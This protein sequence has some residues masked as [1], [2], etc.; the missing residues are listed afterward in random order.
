[1]LGQ[2]RIVVLC[3]LAVLPLLAAQGQKARIVC[4]FSNWAIYRP[5]VGRY[6]IDDIPAEM[7]T[8]IIYSF[9]G[10]DDTN[11]Y[12]VLV[13]DPEVDLE[14]SGFRNF[15]ELR[16][17]YPHAKY[18][19]AV[20]GWAEGGKKY[21]QMVAVKE[22]RQSFIASVVQFMKVYNFDGFDLD[23]EYPGAADRGGSF[24][25]KDKFFYFVE[26]LRR[27]FDREGRGW[28]I[29][30]A[31]PVAN[32]RLQEG[33][34]VP[35]LCENLDAIHC[36]TYDLRGNWA[37]FADVHSPLYKR[38]HDQWAYEKLNVNDGVQLWVNYGCPPNKLVV[39]VPFYGRTFTLSAST[40][41]PTLGSYINKEAGGG[42]PGPYTNATGFLAYYEICTEVQDEEKGWTKKWDDVGL[43][44]YTYKGTQFVGYEDEKSLRYKMDW[45]KQKGYAGAMTWAIDM[46]DF[47]GLCGPENAL[48]KVLY[49]GMKDY[50][51]PEP[52]V[53]TTPRPEWNRPPSTM[54]SDGD[55]TSSRPTTTT[56]YRP[57]PTSTTAPTTRTTRRTTVSS[58]TS[59]RKPT[60]ILPPEPT[61]SGEDREPEI[62][63]APEHEDESEI[64]CSGY[65]DFVPS[66]D[67]TKYYRCVHGQPVEFVCKPGTV[68]HTAL[69][70]CDWPENA[71]RPECRTKAKLIGQ[72]LVADEYG[73]TLR[74]TIVLL[75]VLLGQHQCLGRLICHYTT[76][77]QGRA[78]PYS[79]RI[80]DI[81]GELCTHVVYNFVGVDSEE[82]ELAMLQREIDVVQN[83]FGRFVDL[84]KR[85]PD[86]KMHVAVGGWDHGGAPFSRMAAYRNRR[87]KFIESVVKFMGSY[88]FDGIEL[89][90]LYPGSVER[91]GTNNDKDNF[92]YLVEE[93]KTAFLK[94]RQPWEVAIQVPADH[95]RFEVGYDQPLLCES[96]DFVHI[97][98]YDLRGSW[99]GFADVHSPMNDRPHDQ[100]IY[101]GLNVKAGVESWLR[102]GCSPSKVILGVPFLGRTYTLRNSQQ[103]SVGSLTSG[104]GQKGQH[105]YTEGYLGYFEI[106]QK[107]KERNWRTFWD[108]VG[109]CPYTY[110]GNQWI[111]YENEQSLK[112]KVEFVKAK[113]L[114]GIYAFSLDLDDYRGKCGEPYPLMST[115]ASLLKK[116]HSSEIGFAFERGDKLICY[117]TNWSHAR[118]NE[119]S[120]ELEDIPGQ[121]C[122][123]VA[124]AFVGVD[125]A[126]SKLVSRKPEYDEDRN[127]FERFRDL[128]VR[129]AHLRLIVSVGGWTHGGGPFSKMASER[130]TRLQ[131]VASAVAFMEQYQLDGMEIVW[132][133]PGAPERGGKRV[134]KDNFYYLVRELREGFERAGKGWEVSVQVPVDRARIAVGYQQEWL[135]QAADYIHLAGY[136]LRGPWTGYADV[137]SILKR[138]SHDTHYYYTFNIEDGIAAWQR[139]GCRADQLVLGLPL[140][141]R[142]YVLK[143]STIT[144]PGAEASGPGPV[145]PITNDPGLLGYFELCEMLKDRNWTA[146]WD[147][148][149]QAPYVYRADQWIGYESEQ[150]LMVKTQWV[151]AQGLGGIYAYTLDLDDYRGECDARPITVV[152]LLHLLVLTRF[153]PLCAGEESRLVCYFTNWSPDRDGEYAFNVNDIPVDLCTHVTYTFAGVDEHTFELR[154]TSGKYDILEQGYERFASLK[155]ANPDVKL[156]L[157]VGGWAHGAEPFQKMAATLNGREVFIA[158]VVEFLRRYDFDGIEIVWLWPGSP[159][160]GGTAS[161][162][163]NLYLLIAELKSAFREA[164]HDAWEVI[165]QVPLDRYRIELGYHQSQLC[166]VAD[167]VY[168]TGYDLRGSWNGFT[169]VHSPI[170]N[171]PFDTGALKDLN[172]KG[173]IQHWIK[174]GCPARKIVLGVPLFG[175]TYTLQNGDVHGLAAPTIGPG[176]AG[177]HTKD[178]GYRAYFE[179]C[180]DLKQSAW[181]IDW[182]ERG[183]CPYAYFGDQWVGYENHISIMEKA[184]FAK[185]QGL[186]GVYAFSLDLDDYRGK[187]GAPYP[188]LKALRN[189][190]KPKKLCAPDD[191]RDF[192]IFLVA[193]TRF[194][195]HYTTWSRD[196]PDEGSFQINDIPGNLCS[197]VV[198]NFLGV[199]ETSYQL[200]LLQPEY[201][202]GERALERFAALKDQYPHLKLLIAVG[203][204]A[205]G[206]ARFSE[207]AKF[208][209]RRNQFIG[210]VMKFLHQYR[211][212]GIELVWLYPGNF[213][214]G[215]A[216]EDKDTFL[217]LVS[218]LAKVI[219][220]EAK[221]WELVI[222]VPV[223]ISRMS[224]GYHQ[225]ELCA[226][227]DFVHMV[228]YD[229]RGWW[230]NFADVH[231]PLAPR[232]ND[233]VME[234]FEHVNVGDGVQDWLD[235]GCPPEKVTLG[236]ALFGRTYLLDDPLDNTIGAVTIG[237]GDPGPYSNE[238]GYL[239]YCEFCGNL[240]SSEWTKKWDD[241]GLCPYAY[242]ETTW[243]G[244]EDE[245]SLQEKINYVKRKGLGGLYAFSLDLDDYRGACGDPFPLTRFLSKYHDE[246]KIKDWHIFW[247]KAEHNEVSNHATTFSVGPVGPRAVYPKYSG[248]M[249]VCVRLQV[250]AET[251]SE[252]ECR[253]YIE[254]AIQDLKSESGS[255]QL[256]ALACREPERSNVH[257]LLVEAADENASIEN[258]IDVTSQEEEDNTAAEEVSTEETDTATDDATEEITP[259]EEVQEQ[260]FADSA[261]NDEAAEASENV[262]ASEETEQDAANVAD[263][264]EEEATASS[265]D[266]TEDQEDENVTE[267]VESIVSEEAEQSEEV[268][269]ETEELT[270]EESANQV[271][272]DAT[273]EEED[274]DETDNDGEQ[275]ED[276][277]TEDVATEEATESAEE[278][279]DSQEVEADAA[280]NEDEE[281][282][283]EDET[284]DGVDEDGDDVDETKEEETS[285][286]EEKEEQEEIEAQTSSEDDDDDDLEEENAV[287]GS[288][289]DREQEEIEI[290]SAEAN[291]A[292]SEEDSAREE[293]I[294]SSED[295]DQNENEELEGTGNSEEQETTTE[296]SEEAEDREA[297][298][299]DSEFASGEETEQ[300]EEADSQE[301]ADD[302]AADDENLSEETESETAESITAASEEE[303]SEAEPEAT[304]QSEEQVVDSQEAGEATEEASQDEPSAEEQVEE[305]AE[306]A[307]VTEEATSQEEQEAASAEEPTDSQQA[308]EDSAEET[309]TESAEEETVAAVAEGES[310]EESVVKQDS[311]ESLAEAGAEESVEQSAEASE[312]ASQDEESFPEED[313]LL[314]YEIPSN[315][316]DTSHVYELLNIND[317]ASARE[318]ALQETA[319]VI[320]RDLKRIYDNSIKPLETLYKY[321]DLSNRHF[322][323]PEIFSKPLVLFMGPWSGGKSTILNY[324]THN[325]YTPNSV[326]TGAEP[327]P[328]Y[329][330]I[331]MHGDE[332]EVLDGTQLAADWTFSGLQKFGQ[333][334][335]DR[336]RG[337]K[338]PN[339]LLERVNIVEIPGILEVRKQ[340]SKYFPFND[341]CQWF[342][343]RADIIFLV[344]DPSKLDVGP[345]TEAIL[346]QLKGREY[347]TRIL[348]NKADQVK[349]EE[350]LRVQSALIWNISPLM[351]SAQPPVMYTVSLWSNP[352]EVGAPVRLL[353]AQ[354]RSLLLDLGQAIDRRI[355]NKIASARRFAVRVRNHAKMVDCYLTTYYNHKT[356][357]GNKK[358]ISEKIIASPQDYHIYEG[359]STL[360]NIS[361]YDLPDPEVYRDF[362]HLNP[363]YEFKKLSET[364]TYFRG[365]PINKL[366]VAIAYDLPELVGKYK[367]MSE[368]A[369]A[370]LD[371][372]T[373]TSDFGKGK[374]NTCIAKLDGIKMGTEW[375]TLRKQA[376][377]LE[378]DI[379]MKL[380]AFNK[381]GVGASSSVAATGNTDTSPLLGNHVFESL[382]LE[383]EQ[384]LDKLSNINEKMSEIPNSGAAVMHVLQRH[385]E[386]LHGY[387][388]EYLKIQANHTTR[389]EREELLRG[390]GLGTS[391]PSTSGLSRRDMYLKENTHLHSS[392]SLVNDQ[393]SIAMETKE[394]LTSQRQHLK[395]FQTRMHDISNRFPLISSLIQ[396][397][398]IRKRRESLIIGGVIAVCTI[399]LLVYAFH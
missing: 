326:R 325:E 53:T 40:T 117:Y 104:P 273:E 109:Q 227:A 76:W 85:F 315:L 19:I 254:K 142:S 278:A 233:L 83:G 158:S 159:D 236:V 281:E 288:Y 95:T 334:L 283:E 353:Q 380:I 138:R 172:V 295:T 360:T 91:G 307:A 198:Y 101:K 100:G 133:W 184:R 338:L 267:E 69:N 223:D 390:S 38:P 4:Y 289:D 54:S 335:L 195:C 180:T 371:V 168:L 171:R 318:K 340:V 130:H 317:D 313:L 58:T 79:Y 359:L 269:A 98:G 151:A 14:Q 186:A 23:W 311:E 363:L 2:S 50:V 246:T 46:D 122:T 214:R 157:A 99:T 66:A 167:Y 26:E 245:R 349:P 29:T 386:I 131:F 41:N 211:L 319:D 127:G 378:N 366:D 383:I 216:V 237:A 136:D 192:A 321:R 291:D 277:E 398:N 71:D 145:G 115:L 82:Y 235:K 392:S 255:K 248:L 188:L 244:Y 393:I 90:W 160:R 32:F 140:Y 399:L 330:N 201:D 387:R 301:N 11:N 309:A 92:V 187:C 78:N 257:F 344:Y 316:R 331:L 134:D 287:K 89:V 156:S 34:H 81:P 238:P 103:N 126:T 15:T 51:V 365:C 33:Y 191:E 290:D 7:C 308:A 302:A 284:P 314:E 337:Q 49:E 260:L 341:A 213:D 80:E 10:V 205:H 193:E 12:Q 303:D 194:V 274:E 262:E 297:L 210:S 350:L 174:N 343:D 70:V 17:R 320:L 87:K 118:P 190:Y 61:D 328:A 164:G 162:K 368:A 67:C 310:D 1:M 57:R 177:P 13:I 264:Q 369:L 206:G 59:T 270:S 215:G 241:V 279:T 226:A 65:K 218:E 242:T 149:A 20:G 358:Q 88:G 179:I 16:Q 77:S 143:N 256:E 346:D 348:L 357:F 75:G 207:M 396:R 388:Q 354:E 275:D 73:L 342:I 105:T 362:F 217:Y 225:E 43:C 150:S 196:R 106:C 361:R 252:Y 39:G 265:E 27:A 155:K 356:L 373:P 394:H 300:E 152:W 94:A 60:T 312:T 389:M 47:H 351:S 204:W 35:E 25:D 376:R 18:Q 230:N 336:L 199:N 185:S 285:G 36:M 379:D 173:G 329:F 280:N 56:T 263:S 282:D 232:P 259:S 258:T 306:D 86:L 31:V 231:S 148:M 364:C 209:T 375:D 132:L 170:N 222:Q 128:K 121:L 154:P 182:D 239:G 123:H 377:H 6:T 62:P 163:D 250:Q 333:G 147:S 107:M 296:G 391:S 189:A 234:S 110:R 367:K 212:D 203:G 332:P 178:A 240:T 176:H 64:D 22:R 63:V 102:S 124:Y 93:L 111:G 221:Q 21:S 229:L 395:R 347:Q 228:G 9:I 181:T 276:D 146:G 5:D 37:G 48:M 294:A 323:D 243:I 261:E 139:K 125:E 219:R 120:Y 397:I 45:I 268:R 137:H 116:S 175:R 345:E 96:A 272:E 112:E 165:V 135:C 166:R 339:K 299:D 286:E 324:L 161:D 200:E 119:H 8:H 208:R 202:L 68:F 114:A 298:T 266:P 129:F 271:L 382:S 253:P 153:T 141:G 372:L 169:D 84:K 355:E 322:G 370:K 374:S 251:P 304:E 327:S 385:R 74:R 52:T 220:D 249:G 3:L 97:I 108:A 224:V 305:S 28:E 292:V 384:M 55:Q 24:G 381:V 30:M 352:Y 144:A 113:E 247:N 42:D 44:P 72:P 293:E 183:M 197:H